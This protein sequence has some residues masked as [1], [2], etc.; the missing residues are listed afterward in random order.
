MFIDVSYARTNEVRDF[1]IYIIFT[2]C[3][4]YSREKEKRLHVLEINGSSTDS[5]K[6]SAVNI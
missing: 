2:A 1:M 6:F 3:G 5:S 4:I